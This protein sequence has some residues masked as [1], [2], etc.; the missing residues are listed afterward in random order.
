MQKSESHWDPL[1]YAGTEDID[2]PRASTTEMY[3]SWFQEPESKIKVLAD[4]VSGKG[5]LLVQRKK[6]QL[7]AVFPCS[8]K[9]YF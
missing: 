8:E 9:L 3:S 4:S 7:L 2:R 1:S 6:R 5:C